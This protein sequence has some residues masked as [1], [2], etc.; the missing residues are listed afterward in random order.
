MTDLL[1][2]ADRTEITPAWPVPLAGYAAR[3]A[4]P[5]AS[6]V[7]APLNLRTLAFAAPDPVVLISADLLWWGDDLVQE[8]RDA[9][10][11]QLGIERQ[12]LIL[13]A[14]HT[15]SGPQTAR[16]MTPALG[17]WDERYLEHLKDSAVRS[18][19]RALKSQQP[20]QLHRGRANTEAGVD[21]RWARTAGAVPQGTIDTEFTYL[22]FRGAAGD[23]VASATHFACH[24]VL[25][26]GNAVTGDFA[27]ALSTAIEDRWSPVSLYL[28]GCCGDVNPARYDAAGAFANGAQELIEQFAGSLLRT[29]EDARRDSRPTGPPQVQLR[30]AAIELPTVAPEAAGSGEEPEYVTQWRA[31]HESRPP[32][33][34]ILSGVRLTLTE[35][36]ELLGLSG[37]PVSHYGLV[38]KEL[39]GGACLPMGYTDGMSTYLVTDLQREQGGY[40]ADQAP[41]Y[42]GLPG[43]V[44]SGAEDRIVGLIRELLDAPAG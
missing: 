35:G 27:G 28:Q 19:Q 6:E 33:D 32:R 26:H 3:S 2:G 25:H 15:H 31:L 10:H 17:A 41:F 42:F 1:L 8:V 16:Y 40:E 21:R 13:H 29:A 34:P 39:S 22:E 5:P 11:E 14:T 38:I 18:V 4:G 23:V 24:P 12:S 7:L 30:R 43:L 37:E 20:V 36:L 9:A 44:A